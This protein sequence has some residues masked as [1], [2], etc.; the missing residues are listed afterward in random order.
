M[1]RVHRVGTTVEVR[2]PDEG[3]VEGRVT[4]LNPWNKPEEE[5]LMEVLREP[6]LLGS[7][8]ASDRANLAKY[9]TI[10]KIRLENA[11]AVVRTGDTDR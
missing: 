4:D 3:W 5:G 2:M 11:I 1:T 7:I 9:L 6:S 10:A 8:G